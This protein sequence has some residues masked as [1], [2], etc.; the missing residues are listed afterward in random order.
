MDEDL[1]GTEPKTDINKTWSNFKNT[2]TATAQ[3]VF[4]LKQISKK[5]T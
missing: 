4:G 5:K 3:D 2:V 1:S